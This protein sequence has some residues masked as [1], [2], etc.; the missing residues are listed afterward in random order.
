MTTSLILDVL[1]PGVGSVAWELTKRAFSAILNEAKT[2]SQGQE[3]LNSQL[4]LSDLQKMSPMELHQYIFDLRSAS[5]QLFN[6]LD[7]YEDEFDKALDV[8]QNLVGPLTENPQL[9]TKEYSNTISLVTS[10]KTQIDT[11]AN[12][13]AELE[14][15][16]IELLR[17]DYP[18]L[19][20]INESYIEARRIL[21]ETP[22]TLFEIFSLEGK[23]ARLAVDNALVA[24]RNILAKQREQWSAEQA[25]ENRIMQLSI[26]SEQLYT[27][28]AQNKWKLDEV[29]QTQY[30]EARNTLSLPLGELRSSNGS[31]ALGKVSQLITDLQI[32]IYRGQ[33][34]DLAPDVTQSQGKRQGRWVATFAVRERLAA[35]Q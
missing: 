17:H 9:L 18:Y 2:V 6:G 29:I 12:Y 13:R 15:S 27:K 1:A 5:L 21:K 31:S 14:N 28:V 23:T 33:Q 11:I 8:I 7:F 10:I 20:E 35:K 3:N 32:A 26:N 34:E 22:K 19:G 4:P 25:F 24:L 30:Q 16:F